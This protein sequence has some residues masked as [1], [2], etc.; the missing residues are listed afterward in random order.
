MNIHKLIKKS[1]A[2]I[3]FFMII[4]LTACN[5]DKSITYV[6]LNKYMGI[7]DIGGYT[8]LAVV[9][10]GE[11]VGS[12]FIKDGA[13]Y[14]SYDA[15]REYVDDRYYWD[16]TLKM[17]TY[18]SSKHVYDIYVGTSEYTKDKEANNHQRDIVV[19]VDDTA[20]IDKDFV[21]L[22]NCDMDI[23]VYETPN[24]VVITTADEYT[25]KLLTKDVKLEA[26]LSS[27]GN[28]VKDL[29]KD[30]AVT[31]VESEN[32]WA[33]IT[34]DDGFT[35]YVDASVLG[36]DITG[37]A[38]R[39]DSWLK[40]EPY[41]Y[42]SKD[43]KICLGWHQMEYAAGNDALNKMV[44]GADSLNVISP[45]W[46]KVTDQYGGISS[47][48]SKAYVDKAHKKG[49]EVWGLISDFNYDEE[50]NYYINEVVKN[51]ISRRNLIAN[52]IS[53]AQK[54]GMDGINIDFEMI[55]RV[56]ATGYVQFMRELAIECD[57]IGLVLSV[58]MY[59][60]VASNG[61]Y[62]RESVGE[63]ADYLIIMG[64]DEHWAGCGEAGSVASLPYVTAGIDNTL[65][66]VPA[67]RVINAVPFYTRVWYEDTL[68]NA[69]EGAIIVKDPINGDYALSSKALGMDDAKELI[70]KNNGSSRWL[71]D[72]G[73]YYSEYYIG[74]RFAR[75][76][77]E[78]KES[79]TLKLNVM[80]DRNL[81]GV[82]GWKLGLDS[83]EAWDV[84][85]EYMK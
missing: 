51:T 25:K 4:V 71:E 66:E 19:C 24:R 28:I 30:T 72:M 74:D 77:L 83:D 16:E 49:L 46:F 23:A 54:C 38:Q 73:Q 69:P 76:W 65:L 17:L 75:I 85:A 81:A 5:N 31:V 48:A 20:Y 37:T 33:K 56:A 27:S 52:I 8:G 67:S 18:A 82:A 44:S 2:V 42:I 41:T 68:E 26:D 53:E 1:V 57:K 39:E 32:G 60:P 40:T 35:G 45:T 29:S 59:V 78:D 36:G 14:L 6:D 10:D 3:A 79:L 61:Y 64:Y 34:T 13:Y 47:L 50:G 21:Y 58:D 7:S 22:M 70:E 55:R 11:N 9:V 12:G 43:Y 63:V 84:I 15:V 62:D 80:K